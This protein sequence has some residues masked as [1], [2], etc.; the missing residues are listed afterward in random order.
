MAPAACFR[1]IASTLFAAALLSLALLSVTGCS[2][3][4][5]PATSPSTPQAQTIRGS[6]YGGQQPVVG[7]T[8][9]LYAAGAPTAGGGY[10]VGATAL[11]TGTL[12][13]TDSHGSFSI[14]GDY[15]S[16]LATPSYFY[17]VATGGSPGSG[18]PA[19]PSAVMIS[20]ISGCTPTTSLSPSLFISINEVSTVVAVTALQTF[21]A[22]PSGTA[23]DPVLIGAPA[24]ATNDLRNGFETASSL[25]AISNGSVVIPGDSNGQRINTLADILAYC[26]NSSPPSTN[27]ST[28]F[29]DVTPSG[30]TPAADTVQ[31]AW[32]IAQN[33]ANNIAALFGLLPPSPP[34]PA[35]SAAPASFSV[36]LPP[37]SQVG[38]FA[39][40]ADSTITNTGA[41]VV[42][43]GDLGLDPGTAVTG[44]SFSSSVGPGTVISPATQHIDDA[45]AQNAMVDLTAAYNYAAGLGGATPMPADLLNLT[46][47][48]GVYSQGSAVTLSGGTVTLDAQNDPTAVFIFQTGSTLFTAA[49]TQVILTNGAQ[50]KNVFWELGSSA[51]LG[52]GST[53]VGTI[54]AGTSITLG[55]GATVQGRV[56][57]VTGAVTFA[58]NTVTAP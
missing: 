3:Q 5:L 58:D 18:N 2:T 20:V 39:V 29:S 11:I 56:L 4:T 40:L 27:C 48:P 43:G 19:N 26:I 23:G 51:T 17:I 46:F 33:P 37:T 38:C 13:V 9:Q 7:A 14:T 1:C 28:L 50:A 44:F 41:T 21:M 54:M 42:S 32:Y 57:A 49:N 35:L 55:T 45:I 47:T 34:F 24:V 31:A 25:A 8:I 53:F 36:A 30:S 22:A 52:P 10:G 15:S 16:P 12:P 6:V